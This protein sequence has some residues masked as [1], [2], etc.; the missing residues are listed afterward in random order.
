MKNLLIILA[1]SLLLCNCEKKNDNSNENNNIPNYNDSLKS[2]SGLSLYWDHEIFGAEGRRLRFIFSDTVLHP[3]EYELRFKYLI[4]EDSILVYLIDTINKGKC[5]SFEP[6]TDPDQKC[7]SSGEFYIPDTLIKIGNYQFKLLTRNFSVSAIL[8]VDSTNY[9][10]IIPENNFFFCS[11]RNVYPEPRDIIFGSI[12]FSGSTNIN[13]ADS[14]KN[15]LIHLGLKETSIP[16]VP[17]RNLTVGPDGKPIDETWPPNNYSFGL[18]YNSN[19]IAFQKIVE[20]ATQY[21]E[22]SELNI[23]LYSGNGDQARFNQVEGISVYY[24]RD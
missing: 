22:N 6:N 4:T 12:V 10:L 2:V 3:F 14:F 21:F 13:E 1:F 9:G 16:D 18:L 24:A 15:A 17:Y 19:N 5:P 7:M 20:K 11:I 23:Y 8:N